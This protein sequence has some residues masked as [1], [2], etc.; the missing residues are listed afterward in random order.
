MA[1][2]WDEWIPGVLSRE[3]M[4]KLT[5]EGHL[6]GVTDE[7][8]IDYSAVD[9]HLTDEAYKMTQGSIKPSGSKYLFQIKKEKLVEKL[10]PKEDGTFVLLPRNTYLFGIKEQLQDLKGTSFHGQATAKSSIGRI[11]VLT[12]LI[13][14]GMDRYECFTPDI[15]GQ[16]PT[17]LFIDITP[18][19]FPVKVKPG[20]SLSQLRIFYGAPWECTIRGPELFKTCFG[21][22]QKVDNQLAVDLTNR[23]L[24]KEYVCGYCT[25]DSDQ[26]TS[27]PI[28]L[29]TDET[30]SQ[31]PH[32][33]WDTVKSNNHFRLQIEKDRFY[34][35]RSVEKLTIPSGIAVYARAIDEEIGE[36]RIHYAGFVHPFFGLHRKDDI[37]GTPLIFEVRGHDVD[38]NL[39]NNEVLAK[40][41]FY[42]MSLDAIPDEKEDTAYN[43]QSLQLSK[44]F[45][46]W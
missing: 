28:A 12:R 8:A 17:N 2:P 11:D 5:D 45:N 25:L 6:N 14:D 18:M 29:W 7:K 27:D 30:I 4:L 40:L 9:L 32:I 38:V 33:Y 19:T 24:K 22:R 20:I 46:P 1:K 41:I 42:R 13:V 44:F 23:K 21:N 39:S 3:Q 43:Q 35:F 36:M 26:R 34:I 16:G 15:L 10:T 37:K 31:D